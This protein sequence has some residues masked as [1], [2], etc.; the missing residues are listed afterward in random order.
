MKMK[1]IYL[2]FALPLFIGTTA[3]NDN[4]SAVSPVSQMD[5][6]FMM[7]AG[8]SNR[9]EIEAGQMAAA[10]AENAE[11]KNFG[12]MMVSD[13]QMAQNELKGIA[14]QNNGAVGDTLDAEHRA[15]SAQLSAMNGRAFD[16]MYIHSQVKDH[17]N[18][19]NMLQGQMNNGSDQMLK[20]YASKYLPKVRMHYDMAVSLANQYK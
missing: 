15:L 17:M 5:R 6:N 20:D 11:I 18:A 16:S 3:C 12:S 14:A 4:D 13:H 9:A 2:A 10:K 19:M 1:H 7:H 8:V